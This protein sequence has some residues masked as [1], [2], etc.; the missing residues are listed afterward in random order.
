MTFR[1]RVRDVVTHKCSESSEKGYVKTSRPYNGNGA[2]IDAQMSR[3]ES[4]MDKVGTKIVKSFGGDVTWKSWHKIVQMF[5]GG[6]GE[7][8]W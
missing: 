5:G 6:G 8:A 3:G 2:S 4:H 7:V 1:T